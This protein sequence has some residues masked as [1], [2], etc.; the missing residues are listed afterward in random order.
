MYQLKALG[1]RL[2]HPKVMHHNNKN[3]DEDFLVSLPSCSVTIMGTH[4]HGVGLEEEIV[5]AMILSIAQVNENN[6]ID[7]TQM[8][9]IKIC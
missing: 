9:L 5:A 6:Q 8:T 2:L 4:H 7:Q 1:D 3:N